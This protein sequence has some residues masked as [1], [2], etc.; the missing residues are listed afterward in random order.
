MPSFNKRNKNKDKNTT[1]E[2]LPSPTSEIAQSASPADD[3]IITHDKEIA[4]IINTL[5]VRVSSIIESDLKIQ[6]GDAVILVSRIMELVEKLND[7]RVVITSRDK[8]YITM[9]VSC[10]VVDMIHALSDEEKTDFKQ[11][12]PSI[13]EIVIKATKNDITIDSKLPMR[14]DTKVDTV[15]L[16]KK[17]YE[18]LK[19]FI[20]EKKFTPESISIN[21]VL[22]IG[23]LINIANDYKTV[24]LSDRNIIITKSL[25]YL[26]EDMPIL[27]PDMTEDQVRLAKSV[28]AITP[29]IINAILLASNGSF[30]INKIYGRCIGCCGG[31]KK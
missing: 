28:I 30:D 29:N 4:D 3:A 14:T 17:L 19:S 11:L 16:T 25:E 10:K 24:S 21:L 6:S 22:I 7:S 1:S 13:I 8:A 18:K 20:I 31:K 12:I 5:I 2:E 15:I 26:V 9:M 23:Y 27:F